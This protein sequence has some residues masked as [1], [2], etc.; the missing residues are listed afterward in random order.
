MAGGGNIKVVVRCRPLNAREIARGAVGL[1]RME[2][3]QTILSRPPDSKT[4]KESE[5]IKL[6]PLTR[7]IGALTRM[8]PTM[9]INKPCTMIW[10]RIY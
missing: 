5:D 10:E 2:G 9:P 1:I 8:H 6:S 4:G 7:V 3:N